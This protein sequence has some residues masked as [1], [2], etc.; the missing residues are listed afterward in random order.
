MTDC[1]NCP[2]AEAVREAIKLIREYKQDNRDLEETLG[3]YKH[4]LDLERTPVFRVNHDKDGEQTRNLTDEETAIYNSWIESEA[5]D[6]GV[7]ITDGDNNA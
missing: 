3:E 5:K 6:T 1:T 4:I 7:N 2:V